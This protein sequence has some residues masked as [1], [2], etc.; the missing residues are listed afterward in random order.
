MDGLE[1]DDPN[2][3]YCFG[4]GAPRMDVVFPSRILDEIQ[5][6]EGGHAHAA[7]D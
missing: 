5:G 1:D 3:V 7:S 2:P 6:G 4:N